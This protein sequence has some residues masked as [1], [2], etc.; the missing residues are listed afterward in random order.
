MS[1]VKKAKDNL[2]PA[3]LKSFS[4]AVEGQAPAPEDAQALALYASLVR[5][6]LF[7]KEDGSQAIRDLCEVFP[8]AST[9]LMVEA[10][11]FCANEDNLRDHFDLSRITVEE[12][13][14]RAPKKPESAVGELSK[15]ID[16]RHYR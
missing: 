1:I 3:F 16:I 8:D 2:G 11:K 9:S 4:K 7:P 12:A 14:S 15:R 5:R 13:L 6:G 10:E